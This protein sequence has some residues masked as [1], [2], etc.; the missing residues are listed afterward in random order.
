MKDF[1]YL[2]T[3]LINSML[4][5]L[6]QGIILKN[7]SDNTQSQSNQ[8]EGGTEKSTEVNIGV[9]LPLTASTSHGETEIDKYSVIYSTSNTQL[10]ETAFDD[11]AFELLCKKLEKNIKIDSKVEEG[12]FI[13]RTAKITTYDFSK[14]KESI[15]VNFIKKLNPE[16]FNNYENIKKE[17]KKISKVNAIKHK[18]KISELENKLSQ[19]LPYLFEQINSFSTYMNTLFD[20]SKIIKIGDSLSIC[21]NDYIRITPSLLSIMNMGN[22]HATILGTVI[23]KVNEEP[24][25]ELLAKMEASTILSDTSNSFMDLSMQTFKIIKPNDYYVRPIAIYFE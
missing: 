21:E 9:N 18:S 15:D 14:L 2:N 24:K 16:I 10:V 8:E 12:D 13:Q 7:I 23:A 6:D 4:A 25:I 5:Q 1:I 17:L 22:K 19:T 3:K 11:Y 20:N